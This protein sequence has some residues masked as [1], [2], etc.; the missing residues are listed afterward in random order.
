[1]IRA[2]FV[3]NLNKPGERYLCEFPISSLPVEGYVVIIKREPYIVAGGLFYIADDDPERAI[4]DLRIPEHHV[5]PP[6]GMWTRL[7]QTPPEAT[8]PPGPVE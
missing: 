6:E 1:M 7:D 5:R 2:R 8:F 3:V 4:I